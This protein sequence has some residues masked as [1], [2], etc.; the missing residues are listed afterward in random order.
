MQVYRVIADFGAFTKEY[1][2]NEMGTRVGVV[3]VKDGQVLLVQQYRLLINRLSWELPGGRVD[4]AEKPETAAVR[5]CLE[6]TGVRCLN[7]RPLV[8]YYPGLDISDNPTHLFF[9][10]SIAEVQEPQHVDM[11]EV[12][13]WEWM[14]LGQCIEMI[15]HREIQDSL[16][17]LGLLAYQTS[18]TLPARWE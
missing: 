16:S 4:E 12:S 2:V 9:C 1:F 14:P 15:F 13:R 11:R 10:D 6:E 18:L 8:F 3:A 5:E 7:V 17:I